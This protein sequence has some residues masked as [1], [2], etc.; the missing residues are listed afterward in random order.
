MDGYGYKGLFHWRSGNT[1]AILHNWVSWLT[2]YNSSWS[3]DSWYWI[4]FYARLNGTTRYLYEKDWLVGDTE[5]SWLLT[6]SSTSTTH[7]DGQP[8]IAG[9]SIP[10]GG[11]STQFIGDWDDVFVRKCIYPDEPTYSI[12]PEECLPTVTI[13]VSD[14]LINEADDGGI[15]DVVATFSQAMDTGVTP[16]ISFD[17][18][19]VAS[20]TL[21]FAGDAWSSGSTVYTASY[22][23]ADVDEEVTNVDVSV[24][25]AEDLAGN[26]QNPDPTIEADL[27]DIDTVAPTV[28]ITSTAT[29]PTNISP[30]PMMAT[31]GE[32]V[33]GF[34]LGDIT[35][36]N[37]TASNFAGGPAVYT[38]DV[39]PVA[40]GPVTAD[41]AA[42]VAQDAA[43]NGNTAATQFAIAYDAT[44]QMGGTTKDK[45][46]TSEDVAV[47]ASGFLPDSDVDVYVVR[48]YHWNDGNNI[49]P[50]PGDPIFAHVLLTA[51]GSGDITN[52]VVWVHTLEIGEYDVVFDAGGDGFYDELWD[53]VDNP[54]H[55]GFTVVAAPPPPPSRSVGGTV[56]PID[57]TAMLL[58]WLV[59]SAVLILAASCLILVRCRSQR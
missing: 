38:F 39:T 29:D 52:Q 50:V 9:S 26:R 53:L 10:S 2:E 40:D 41:I 35:L 45:Y 57:K 42:G 36:A 58:P 48:D 18:D 7:Q 19:V 11:F 22:D 55:P 13:N 54:N 23:I 27:F 46:Y 3:L 5:P 56:Y 43:G 16:S 20:G 14:T 6:T 15:F 44:G 37:G 24:G 8:C 51:D 49:P 25:G 30:I 31:F 1:R 21:T 32:D 33:S 17:S 59:L 4:C 47:T 28:N 34:M 12:G